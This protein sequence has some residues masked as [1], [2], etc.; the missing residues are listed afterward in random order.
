VMSV[1]WLGVDCIDCSVGKWVR[2][3]NMAVAQGQS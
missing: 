3:A 1:D 2:D